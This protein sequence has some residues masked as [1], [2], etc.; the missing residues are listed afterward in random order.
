M[1]NSGKYSSALAAVAVSCTGMGN[2]VRALS[3]ALKVGSV[4]QE[5]PFI[6]EGLGDIETEKYRCLCLVVAD[7]AHVAL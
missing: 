7:L 6:S 2:A 1:C 5:D 3:G 4:G